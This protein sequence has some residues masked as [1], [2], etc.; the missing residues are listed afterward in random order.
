MDTLKCPA[1]GRS[2]KKS[3]VFCNYCGTALIAEKE[4]T[5]SA[6]DDVV[7]ATP[8]DDELQVN[9]HSKKRYAVFFGAAILVT[10]VFVFGAV[11]FSVLKPVPAAPPPKALPVQSSVKKK[12]YTPLDASEE[13][14]QERQKN[15]AAIRAFRQFHTYIGNRQYRH[16][17]A[18]FSSEFQANVPYDG[19]V[20][21][22]R[23]TL[24]SDPTDVRIRQSDGSRA[25]VDFELKARDREGSRVKV[26]YFQGTAELIYIQGTWKIHEL[27]AKP[28]RGYYE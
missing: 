26:Q 21:G 4:R 20:Q 28:T 10:T 27:A 5:S 13:K 15:D 9:S 18:L 14:R 25:Y 3:D 7:Q 17:Y 23:D 1:C 12:T 24:S 8:N 6:V 16:A 2:V 19:W 11:V 22:Y